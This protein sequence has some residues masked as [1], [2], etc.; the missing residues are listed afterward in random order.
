M[1][2]VREDAPNPQET[3]GAREFRGLI[4]WGWGV[5]TSSWSQ[6]WGRGMDVKQSEGILT[7]GI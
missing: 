7:G 4:G 5:G 3:G 2:S 1:G 6:G